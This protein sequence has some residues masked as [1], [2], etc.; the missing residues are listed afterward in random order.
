MEQYQSQKL[1]LFVTFKYI[2]ESFEDC[3]YCPYYCELV[4]RKDCQEG[5]KLLP[6]SEQI[7][8]VNEMVG[9]L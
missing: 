1:N 2:C 5:Y 7:E 6:R 8:I 3:R 9:W 4:T